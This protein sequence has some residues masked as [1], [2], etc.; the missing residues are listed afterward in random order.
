MNPF[1]HDDAARIYHG[2]AVEVMAT[3]ERE[4]VDLVIADPPYS[5]GG[6]YRADRATRTT[7]EK[8]VQSG[9]I[10]GRADFDGDNRDQ[11]SYGFWCA[12]WLTKAYELV[13]PGGSVLVFADWRQLPVTTDAVQ[14]GGFVWRG[15]VSWDKTE[16]VRPRAGFSS[17]C[18]FLVWGTRG[19][20]PQTDA[21]YLNGVFRHRVRTGESRQHIA[22]KPVPLLVDLMAVAPKGGVVLDPFLGSGSTLCAAK[23]TGRTGLGIEIQEAWCRVAV[24]RIADVGLFAE[25]E[26]ASLDGV[27]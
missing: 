15:I 14:A 22:E 16:A 20:M 17:Q 27:R 19:P 24:D 10:L 1:W 18:E 2:E 3:L 13:R 12:L 8:Y 11:R 26:Q 21:E 23:A 6:N 9:Q 4:S 5:S 7:V 25:P